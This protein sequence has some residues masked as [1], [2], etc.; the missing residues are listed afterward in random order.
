[1]VQIAHP[2][3]QRFHV[4]GEVFRHLFGERCHQ[5]AETVGGA[6]VDFGDKIVDLPLGGTDGNLGIHQS[7]G[8]D[9]LLHNLRAVL[10]FKGTRRGADIDRLMDQGVEFVELQRTVVVSRGQ[11]EAVVDKVFLAG[12]VAGVHGAHLRQADVRLVHKEKKVVGKIIDK[13]KGRRAGFPPRQH[14]GIVFDAGAEAA[15]HEHFHVVIDALLDALRLNELVILLE[16]LNA[17][18]QFILDVVERLAHF[19]FGDDVM[20]RGIDG[21][22]VQDGLEFARDIIDLGNAVDFVPEEFD[23]D[24]RF[25]GI[26]GEYFHHIPPHA[27]GVAGKFDVVAAVLDLGQL[28]Q[29]IVAAFFH[30]GAQG[31]HHVAVVDRV[32]HAVD[33]GNRGD[34]D[35]IP[36][37]RQRR[38]G[39][40]AQTVDFV[41]DGGILFDIGVGGGNVGF[42][43]VVIVVADEEFHR[44]FGEEFTELVAELR[45]Q[46]LVVRQH[47]RGLVHAGDDVGH[48]EG[49]A[50][51]RHPE[52]RLFMISLLQPLHQFFNRLG[53]VA[54]GLIV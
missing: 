12:V 46:H 26:G 15:F 41:V 29:H 47:K 43:L 52:K 13:G 23:A 24:D 6:G 19:G 21:D 31:Q 11:T 42:R 20:R 4:F 8:T 32:A 51:A 10:L 37:F 53:L 5:R 54:C 38:G 35:D 25:L 48:R 27:E 14:A 39:G 40:V 50:A 36:P 33:A 30:A 17:L 22:V 49:F 45:C 3:A 18:P 44:V 28:F 2:H 1:M 9:D 7:R 16:I 34:D